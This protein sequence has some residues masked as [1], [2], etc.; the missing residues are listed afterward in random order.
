MRLPASLDSVCVA[1]AALESAL[2]NAGWDHAAAGPVVLA[3]AEAFAN[4]ILHGSTPES[5]VRVGLDVS[6]ERARVRVVDQGRPGAPCPTE[7]AELPPV[8]STRGRGLYI[9]RAIADVCDV[10]PEGDG[11]EVVLEFLRAA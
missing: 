11:T 1:R 2:R 5:E 7:P 3:A 8:G 9:M 4:A 10:H 6:R